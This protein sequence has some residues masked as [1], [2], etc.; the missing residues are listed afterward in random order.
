MKYVLALAII[1]LGPVTAQAQWAVF[2]I[3]N[4]Q[5]SAVNYAALVEQLSRQATQIGNQVR[6]I[7]QFETELRRMGDMSAVVEIVGFREF[8]ADLGLESKIKTWEDRLLRVDGRGVFGDT[9]G[10]IFIEVTAD[11]PDFDGVPVRRSEQAYK[12]PHDVILTVDEFKAVQN[13]V[14]R[15]RTMLKQAIADTS[16]AMRVAPTVAEQAKLEAVLNAQYSQL[17]AVDAEIAF[18]IA[19]VQAKV[20]EAEAMKNAQAIAEAETRKRHVLQETSKLKTAFTPT[21]YCLLQ[22]V[23]ER[24]LRD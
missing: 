7:Q 22:H 2:D 5:Q 18:S 19:E 3:A 8:K 14:Y 6:Q 9:R 17:A 10:G 24:S 12:Q 4:L 11:F 15:R 13:D 20:A 21:Y 16:E 23:T 1:L